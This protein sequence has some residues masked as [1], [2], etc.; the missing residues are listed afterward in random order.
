[1]THV[2]YKGDNDNSSFMGCVGLLFRLVISISTMVY[3]LIQIESV[4][5]NVD[6]EELGDIASLIVIIYS[7]FTSFHSF[8]VVVA[9]MIA[10]YSEGKYT[11]SKGNS[12]YIIFFM[13]GFLTNIAFMHS[14]D[15]VIETTMETLFIVNIL[16]LI[17]NFQV[18]CLFFAKLHLS[19]MKD[20]FWISSD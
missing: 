1:M 5:N 19:G 10:T 9:D 13:I 6:K 18:M 16:S 7:I 15:G 11:L 3:L 8:G 2:L 14:S 4:T 17:F 20:T 12:F